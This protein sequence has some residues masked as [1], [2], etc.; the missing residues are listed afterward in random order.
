MRV[1]GGGPMDPGTLFFLGEGPGVLESK[2][3]QCFVGPA[4]QELNRYLNGLHLPH[5]DSVY[6]TNLFKEWAGGMP[7]KS[8]EPTQEDLVLSEWELQLELATV[9]PNLVVCLGRHSTRW[10]LGPKANMESVHGILFECWWCPECGARSSPLMTEFPEQ[11]CGKPP[12]RIYVLP[13]VHPAAGLHSPPQAALTAYDMAQLAII[14]GKPMDQWPEMCWQPRTQGHYTFLDEGYGGKPS[15]FLKNYEVG[16]DTEGSWQKPWGFSMSAV[17]GLG[18]VGKYDGTP[19][20]LDP[21]IRWILHHYMGDKKVIE[22]MGGEIPE[23][24][25]DDTNVM[26]YLLGVEPQALK[27]LALRHLG[28]VRPEFLDIA[29][30]HQVQFSA[31]TGKPLKKTKLVIKSPDEIDPK[32]WVDYAGA[33]ADDTRSLKPILWKRIQGLGLEE[34]YEVDRRVL[35]LYA[36]MEQVGLPVDMDHYKEFQKFLAE[37]IEIKTL[38]LQ[39]EYPTLNPGSADQVAEIMFGHLGIPGGK[40]TKGGKRFTTDAKIM[41]HLKSAHPFVAAIVEWRELQKLKTTFVDNLH[42]Y[43]HDGRL[44]FTLLAT[45]VISGRLAAK[46]PNTLAFPKYTVLGKRFRAGV[47]APAGRRLGSWD[48]NQIELRVLALDSGSEVLKQVFLTGDDLH[49]RTRFKIFGPGPKEGHQRRAA[50]EVNFGI[51]MGITEVGLAEQMRKRNYPFPELA[52]LGPL[53]LDQRRKAEAQVCKEWVDKVIEDWGIY[54]YIKGKH[55]EA[56]RYG[57]VRS[58]GGRIRFMGSILSPNKQIREAAEREAQAFGPQAGARYFMKQVEYRIWTEVIK[59]LKKEGWYIEPILDI[60]DDL[61]LEFDE[62]LA[63]LLLPLNE[64]IIASTFDV[65]IP[66]TCKGSIG[67][68]WSEL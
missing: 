40:K 53:T 41:Q 49:E 19:L 35:P 20:T 63:G 23:D 55:A 4:G 2:T 46:N 24:S 50:K 1:R 9:Q 45:R 13:V 21:K 56:R 31:K 26:A 22:A 44:F 11:G 34:I 33:D 68:R 7:T 17:Q 15:G 27:D 66:I 64:S 32:V 57:Y 58:I 10:F 54:S 3:G 61:L 12:K 65:G 43:V 37:E 47:R 59:P 6:V 39:A 48:L 36:R 62:E 5:R 67:E 52:E 8:K 25:F 29:G 38:E 60:H 51:P 30:E 42:E 18:I 16:L 14:L 28:V